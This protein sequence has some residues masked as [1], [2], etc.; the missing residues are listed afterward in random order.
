MYLSGDLA[1]SFKRDGPP[2]E[3]SNSTETPRLSQLA[4]PYVAG[5]SGE[6][7]AQLS[8]AKLCARESIS[9][10]VLGFIPAERRSFPEA[11]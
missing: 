11:V 9:L 7:I 10:C 3:Q 1:F 8:K 2:F 5:S 4:F 6:L